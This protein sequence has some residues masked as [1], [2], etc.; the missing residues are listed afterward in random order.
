MFERVTRRITR[1]TALLGAAGTAGAFVIGGWRAA[2]GF[3]LG[4]TVSWF[5]FRGLKQVVGG[6]G[7]D[8]P[9]PNLALK[10]VVRYLLIG[11]G[12]YVIVKYTV[13]NLL[14]ALA[15]LLLSTA[16]VLVEILIELIYARK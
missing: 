3:A 12:A 10:G 8:R 2:A 1:I 14:A 15:G 4:G 16:A 13:V 9:A 11:A 6:L 7:A 5:S